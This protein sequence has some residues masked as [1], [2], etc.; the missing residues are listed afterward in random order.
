MA[1]TILVVLFNL[2]SG[3]T[4]EAYERFAKEMDIPTVKRLASVDEFRVFRS[5]GRFGAEGPAPFQYVEVIEVN[6]LDG[7][8]ADV[9]D[10]AVGK[11]VAA[12]RDYAENPIFMMTDEI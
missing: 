2:K 12:F 11:V 9:G 7:L 10:P 5:S 1:S 8:I 3:V 4:P 6:N